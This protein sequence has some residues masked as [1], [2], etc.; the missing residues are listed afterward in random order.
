MLRDGSGEFE[1][2]ARSEGSSL[3]RIK[4]KR[5]IDFER[6]LLLLP[7]QSFARIRNDFLRLLLDAFTQMNGAD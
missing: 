5:I 4:R 6:M 1:E 7:I 2:A 3:G